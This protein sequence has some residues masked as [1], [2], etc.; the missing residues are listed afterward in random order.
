MEIQI[1]TLLVL[2]FMIITIRRLSHYTN[3]FKMINIEDKIEMN[4]NKPL[5]IKQYN[6]VYKQDFMPYPLKR[7]SNINIELFENF[8][9]FYD[10]RVIDEKY[11]HPEILHIIFLN[12]IDGYIHNAPNNNYDVMLNKDFISFVTTNKRDVEIIDEMM[13]L[14]YTVIEEFKMDGVI[15]IN[16]RNHTLNDLTSISIYENVIGEKTYSILVFNFGVITET[17]TF[18]TFRECFNYL[19]TDKSSDIRLIEKIANTALIRD[20]RG[21]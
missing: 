10:A 14:K 12:K 11:E 4:L 7:T 15:K 3:I 1:I 20:L 19:F 2:F 6:K 17:L 21:E 8:K 13:D 9:R 18:D 16:K 5:T